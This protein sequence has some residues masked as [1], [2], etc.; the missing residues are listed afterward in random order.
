MTAKK[1]IGSLSIII[2]S[3]HSTAALSSQYSP[4]PSRFSSPIEGLFNIPSFSETELQDKSGKFGIRVEAISSAVTMTNAQ[5]AVRFD[6]ETW[7]ATPLWSYKISDEWQASFELPIIHHSSG[8]LDNS[9]DK[10]HETFQLRDGSRDDFDRNELV[11]GY[12]NQGNTDY[13]LTSSETDIGDLR[14]KL[15]HSLPFEAPLALH[16][17]LKAPT[18]DEK[19]LMS[20]GSWDAG[21]SLSYLKKDLLSIP[22]LA[23]SLE[24]GEHYLS[25]SDQIRNQNNWLT[26]LNGGLFWNVI[27]PVTLKGQLEARTAL[28]DSELEPIGGEALQITLGLS[29]QTSSESVWDFALVEDIKTDSTS[30]VTFLAQWSTEY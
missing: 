3:I 9:I 23:A 11:Y 19:S 15:S 12:S 17:H 26:T 29:W 30:D 28:A 14:V 20:S 1:L 27:K 7:R 6:G 16:V 5:E 21:L 13:L 2:A 22:S 24:F 4:L 8:F 18:G 25:N 10:F